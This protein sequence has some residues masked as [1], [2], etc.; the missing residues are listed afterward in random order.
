MLSVKV[1]LSRIV[2][3]FLS[4]IFIFFFDFCISLFISILMHLLISLASSYR[5][6]SISLLF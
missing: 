1:D 4:S 3:K 6:S 2:C 5:S